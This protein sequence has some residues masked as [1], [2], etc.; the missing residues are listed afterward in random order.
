MASGI[1][2]YRYHP[3]KSP[4]HRAPGLLKL[5]GLLG[6]SAGVFRSGPAAL[7]LISVL[8]ILGA[9]SAGVRPRELLRGIGPLLFMLLFTLALR[10]VKLRPPAFDP[11]GFLGG[12]MFAWG[13][14]ISFAAGALLFSVTTMTELK[15]SIAPVEGFIRRIP[16]FLRA[17]WR[18]AP[19]R[20]AGGTGLSLAIS[21]MLGF[22]PRFF[23]T[24]ETVTC[25]YKARAGKGGVSG[26][27]ALIPLVIER[28]LAQAAETARALEARTAR[29]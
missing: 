3:G 17:L 4:L 21:L 22:L 2:P 20:P 8:I 29:W 25:A 16:A 23:E 10:S 1:S 13:I 15:D 7:G 26:L 18:K 6:V 9:L 28:M 5:L 12:L 24:W 27:T 19:P 14:I 11:A